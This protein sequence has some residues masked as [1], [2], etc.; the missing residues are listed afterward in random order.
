MMVLMNLGE[1]KS[2][3]NRSGSVMLENQTFRGARKLQEK[4]RTKCREIKTSS[5][6]P[7]P[8]SNNLQETVACEWCQD[9]SPDEFM[10]GGCAVC[11]QLTPVSQLSKLSE[12]NCVWIYLLEMEWIDTS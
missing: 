2:D 3:K 7:S 1:E 6:P 5:F 11:G 12:S 4:K 9:M 10:E 8:P